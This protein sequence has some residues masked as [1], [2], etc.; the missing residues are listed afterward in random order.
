MNYLKLRES[1]VLNQ[2]ASFPEDLDIFA[3]HFPGMPIL[4]GALSA[5]LLL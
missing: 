1:A 3:H 5:V 2:P 4:P